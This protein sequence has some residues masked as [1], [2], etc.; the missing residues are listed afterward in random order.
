M[1]FPSFPDKILATDTNYVCMHNDETSLPRI[2]ESEFRYLSV[3]KFLF[4][5]Q[6]RYKSP[7]Q[8]HHEYRN[9][10][11]RR[12]N[13]FLVLVVSKDCLFKQSLVRVDGHDPPANYNLKP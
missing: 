13:I 7:T 5:I 4:V 6:M 10:F 11:E 3:I 12:N 1:I 8:T 9:I 2:T